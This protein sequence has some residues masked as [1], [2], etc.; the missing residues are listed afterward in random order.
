M[1]ATV[2]W[3]DA[4]PDRDGVRSVCYDVAYKP[5]GSQLV[6]GMGNRVLVYG[7]QDGAL[8]HSLKAHK[9]AVYAVS[10]SFDGTRFA[11][12]GAD[13]TIIIWTSEAEGI[14]KYN[15]N[16]SVQCLAFN[17][18]SMQLASATASDFGLWAPEQKSVQ[19]HKVSGK[20]LCMGWTKDGQHLALGQYDGCVSVR[21]RAGGEKVKIQRS[22]PIWSL[23]WNPN[24]REKHDVVA[25][26][27]WDGTLSF[28]QLNGMQVGDDRVLGFDPCSVSYFGGGD[29][30]IVGGTDKTARLCS[31]EGTVLTT[32][33]ER[34]SWV[35]CARARPGHNVIAV[36]S[37]DGSISTHQ[38]TFSTVHGMY[39]E[40]YAY[41]DMMTDVIVQ[42][43]ETEQKVR[44]RCKDYVKKIAVYKDK[45]AVQLPDKLVIYQMVESDD[46]DDMQYRVMTKI[47]ENLKCNLL[48]ITSNHVMLCMEKKILLYTMDGK[49]E[50]TWSMDSVIRYIKVDGGPENGEGV[51]VGLKD[52][53]CLKVFIDNDFPMDLV[54]HGAAVR[55]LD[56]SAFRKKLAVVDENSAVLVYDLET[57]GVV[58]EGK[59]ANSVAWNRVYE[60]MFCYAGDGKI[61][62]KTAD[63][64]VHTQN[65]E[66]FAVGFNAS[67]VYCLHNISMQTVD[68]PHSSS[69]RHY[70]KKED[71]DGAYAV[72]CLGVPDKDFMALGLAAHSGMNMEVARKC[73]IRIRDMRYID[74]VTDTEK[75]LEKGEPPFMFRALSL[76]Y[77]G[78]FIEA[79]NEF[80]EN[81]RADKA[82]EMFTDM[83]MFDQ[84]KEWA[85]EH[86]KTHGGGDISLTDFVNRQAEWAEETSDYES[87]V[88]MYVQAK[89]YEKAVALVG[90]NNWRAKLVEIMKLLDVKADA[91]VLQQCAGHFARWGDSSHAKEAYNKLG[92]HAGLMA[93]HVQ[94][95]QWDDAFA[96][97]K[98]HPEHAEKVHLPYANWLADNDRF[99][100]ARAA[101]RVAGRSEM[102]TRM[103]EQLTHNAVLMRRFKDAGYYYWLMSEETADSLPKDSRALL[104][105]EDEAKLARFHELKDRSEIY[106]AYDYVFRA[107]EEPF[108]SCLPATLLNI[109]QFLLSKF[110]THDEM[111]MG[112]SLS[113]VL[114]TIAKHG[115][116]LG[117][118]KLARFAYQKLQSLRIPA[119]WQAEVDLASVV[120]RSRP[121]VDGE[122][123]LPL[124]F[125]CSTTNPLV[126]VKGDVC[127]NCG[128][129]FVRSLVTFEHLPMVEFHLADDISAKE[130]RRLIN[131]DPPSKA[132]GSGRGGGGGDVLD[133]GGDQRLMFD[134]GGAGD[135]GLDDAFAQQM[136]APNSLITCDRDM[137]RNLPPNEVVIRPSGCKLVKPRYY[138]LMDV[139]TP[140]TVDA[141]G[142]LYETDEYE[143][144]CLEQG[145]TPFTRKGANSDAEQENY[146]MVPEPETPSASQG[147][148]KS[149]WGTARGVATVRG[150]EFGK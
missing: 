29:Y 141:A 51:L 127:I 95:K 56:M 143:L 4:P 11:S 139:D 106:Y 66:G 120:A 138:R 147:K 61:S 48:V 8:L 35:W 149:G 130:A 28:Y 133:S 21:D 44:I 122:D 26:G 71:Y 3:Q 144:A 94:Q 17:P 79:A 9:D 107:M 111:P 15:H 146:A 114:I 88:N 124:C 83:R 38:L 140:V 49:K 76:A 84:A 45:L 86:A 10:W 80:A 37:E 55:C 75:G 103:L 108:S 85:E 70:V 62:I 7:C 118:Y 18:C 121:N 89:K 20:V 136:V 112:I 19:K 34:G 123:L 145:R 63:F 110:A 102:S 64:P 60:D 27:C 128:G 98:Q 24:K 13:K 33:C 39:R 1:R 30:V 57:K 104:S 43:L 150:I 142:N 31:K 42:H 125:R 97:L 101:Y 47:E 54:N 105:D 87:A 132:S 40:H 65:L 115:E 100:E 23:A 113:Y 91:K 82:M 117:A 25:V 109:G 96:L 81:G 6:T 68:V 67:R 59:G 73:F 77:Q 14:L 116:A 52:G 135:V 58:F 131:E 148:K 93:L 90:K 16:E 12:G 92:D 74:L 129:H 134:D 50:R 46:P 41:R 126:S 78:K 99:D 36:G 5:D 119:V 32:V 53:K 2:S 72:A 137:L 69:V 22:A